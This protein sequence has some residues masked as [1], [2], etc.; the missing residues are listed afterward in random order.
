M[1]PHLERL[2]GQVYFGS[3]KKYDIH[4][5]SEVESIPI[6]ENFPPVFYSGVYKNLNGLTYRAIGFLEPIGGQGQNPDELIFNQFPL[7][8]LEVWTCNSRGDRIF[9]RIAELKQ[10]D[11]VQRQG[12]F[13]STNDSNSYQLVIEN[14]SR[15][16]QHIGGFYRNRGAPANP[17]E[18][19]TLELS[20]DPAVASKKCKF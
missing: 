9:R 10:L 7:L 15:D 6:T 11:Y 13:E 19:E 5:L 20:Y 17:G 1:N 16:W 18:Q 14:F 12:I 4:L 3:K 2:N 8:R